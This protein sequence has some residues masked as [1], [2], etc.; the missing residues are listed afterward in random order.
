MTLRRASGVLAVLFTDLVGSTE[1]MVRLGDAAFDE[2]RSEH[3][4]RLREVVAAHGGSDVK[5][6]GDGV[7]ATFPSAVAALAA[8]VAAQETTEH[9]SRSAS[10][11]LL[12]RVGLAIGE[13]AVQDGDVFGTPVVEAAR[14]V[15]A[16]GS[17]QILVT[18]LVR[19]MAGSRA[20]TRFTDLGELE[21]KGLPQP[22][23]VCQAVWTS[24][25][26]RAGQEADPAPVGSPLPTSKSASVLS[27]QAEVVRLVGRQ[28]LVDRLGMALDAAR[29][30]A[31]RL[32]LLTGE[33]GIGKNGLG[34]GGGRPRRGERLFDPLGDRL[35][36]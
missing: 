29:A 17:G 28:E 11:P 7:M 34:A 12:L 23:P 26:D 15:A 32:V 30:G 25:A 1:L 14:L 27:P 35:G 10:R 22:V 3:F 9:Q 19:T 5:N 18:A 31:G 2:L 24:E 16:A 20:P 6:T 13:V 4:A 33:P 36:R 21:L 8:A